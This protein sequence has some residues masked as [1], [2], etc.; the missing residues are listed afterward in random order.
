MGYAMAV[1]ALMVLGAGCAESKLDPPSAASPIASPDG[2]GEPAGP[3]PRSGKSKA[4]SS[5]DDSLNFS[6]T[7]FDG[8]VFELAAHKGTPVVINFWESW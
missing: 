5:Y 8:E 2:A 6:V 4:G 7:T 1:T 3:G